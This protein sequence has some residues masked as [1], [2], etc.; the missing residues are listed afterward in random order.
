MVDA[1]APAILQRVRQPAP[2]GWANPFHND[3]PEFP[4]T[5]HFYQAADDDTP[6]LCRRWGYE[7]QTDHALRAVPPHGARVCK[8]C[9]RVLR[10]LG[11]QQRG[12]W[13]E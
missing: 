9:A 8:T 3:G 4:H 13:A 5:W 1:T 12:R 10:S 6:T 2:G 7:T 11:Y